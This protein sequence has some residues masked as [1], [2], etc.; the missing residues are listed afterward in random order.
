MHIVIFA[1]GTLQPGGA[2]SSA[3]NSADLI[4]AADKGASTAL[5]Y[6]CTPSII[7]G[8]LDSLAGPALQQ[9]RKHT[10]QFIQAPIEKDETD[11]ELAI[12]IAL[13]QGATTITLLGGLGGARFDHTMANVQLLVGFADIPIRII[14]GPAVC[15]LLRGPGQ[16][17]IHGHVDDLLS[18]LPLTDETT[19]IKTQGLYYPLH[20]ETLSFGKP[21]GVSNHLTQP[22]ASVSLTTGLLLLIH[23]NIQELR[24]D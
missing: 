17:S 2:V 4:V 23:T 15:W 24:E 8:D 18:L 21:R 9:A 6:G 3:I 10:S 1:G 12:Q 5:H 16:S 20:G 13:Q 11:T 7:V 14:D 22:T 19:N